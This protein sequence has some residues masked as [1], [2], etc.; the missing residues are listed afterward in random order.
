MAR[1]I[2]EAFQHRRFSVNTDSRRLWA[3]SYHSEARRALVIVFQ[4]LG[5]KRIGARRVRRIDGTYIVS[6]FAD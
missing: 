5:N 3:F 2:L 6:P 4:T 1:P